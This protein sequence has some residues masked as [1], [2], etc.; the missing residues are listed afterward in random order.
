MPA[1]SLVQ[2]PSRA[3]AAVRTCFAEFAKLAWRW[4]PR[5]LYLGDA[6]QRIGLALTRICNANCVF[7]PYQFMAKEEKI[8]MP[9]ALFER[10]LAQINALRVPDVMLPPNVGEPTLAP[11]FLE[12]V[13]KLRQAGVRR[14]EMTTNATYLHRLGIP[15]LV[16][17]GPDTVNISFPG[18]DAAMYQRDY[19]VP[20]YAQTRENI[21]QFL[22]QNASAG[23][24]RRINLWLRGDQPAEALMA[25]PEMQ[26]V[27]ALAHDISVMT[28]VDDWLGFIKPE[29]LPQGYKLQTTRPPLRK[30]P[31]QLLFDL[32]IHP[33][34]QIQ[35]CSCRNIKHDPGMYV[36]NLNELTLAEAYRRIPSVLAATERGQWPDSCRG[37]SMYCD[38]AVSLLGRAR[39]II[40]NKRAQPPHA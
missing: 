7:C 5:R 3:K 22:R 19:R 27:R 24:P 12:K 16:R 32:A 28:E 38:P 2:K 15:E 21:L 35:V 20:F 8:H 39:Q 17:D 26:E 31:C 40:A 1:I 29:A 25:A 14:I 13:Q 18:F 11:H 34:G 33:D 37:C 6:P 30:R 9:D 4:I 23:S 36:G 10:V